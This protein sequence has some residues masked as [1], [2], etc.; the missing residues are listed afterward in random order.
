MDYCQC[1]C[2]MNLYSAI[3]RKASQLHSVH[4]YLANKIVF[5]VRRKTPLLTAGSRSLTGSE[6][7]TVGPPTEK[8]RR[9]SVLRR[10]RGTINRYRSA[11]RRLAT[12]A[13]GVQQCNCVNSSKYIDPIGETI[14]HATSKRVSHRDKQP[15]R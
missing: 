3:S 8:A 11:D 1:Q 4:Q 6:F 2:Q 7:Q 15:N 12:S 9:P 5:N 10:Y 13:T 14:S